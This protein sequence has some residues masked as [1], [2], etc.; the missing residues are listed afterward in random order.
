MF[1]GP[2]PDTSLTIQNYFVATEPSE[3]RRAEARA[4]AEFL[5]RVVREEDYLTGFGLQ[6]A[7]ATGAK[8]FVLFGRNEEG[9]QRFHTLLAEYLSCP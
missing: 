4:Q 3:E 2:T 1:P 9:G 5:E 8:E 7:L 6:R